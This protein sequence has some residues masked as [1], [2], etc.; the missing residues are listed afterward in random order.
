[1]L[2]STN[3]ASS[4]PATGGRAERT[5]PVNCRLSSGSPILLP[6]ASTGAIGS[7]WLPTRVGTSSTS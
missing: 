3:A 5:V 2:A 1:V 4:Q 6:I 7:N